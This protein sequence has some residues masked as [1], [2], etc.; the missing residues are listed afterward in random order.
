EAE[1]NLHFTFFALQ[2]V[3]RFVSE[4]G[5]WPCSWGEL[6]GVPM[7]EGPLG[8]EWPA[9]SPEVQ[10]R[11]TI[12]FG[13]DPLDVAQQAPGVSPPSGPRAHATST[14]IT[15][16]SNPFSARSASRFQGATIDGRASLVER[17]P[18]YSGVMRQRS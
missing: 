11:I 10:R 3:E 16:G 17:D 12:D 15:V 4:R 5:R 13:V 9:A 18:V 14:A 2:L 6:A 8:R 1:N 7:R